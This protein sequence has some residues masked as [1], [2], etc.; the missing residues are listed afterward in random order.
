MI[1]KK[2]NPNNVGNP[3]WL[4]LMVGAL[5]IYMGYQ[6]FTLNKTP[7][8]IDNPPAQ[9][10]DLSTKEETAPE[11]APNLLGIKFVGDITGTGNVATCGQKAKMRLQGIL[12]SGASAELPAASQQVVVGMQDKARAWL[13]AITGMRVGGVREIILPAHAI[14]SAQDIA[15]Y[16]IVTNTQLNLRLF[17]DEL[18]P[19]VGNHD[20]MPLAHDVK[21]GSGAIASC[22]QTALVKFVIWGEDGKRLYSS[23]TDAPEGVE[24]KLG[25]SQLFYGLDWG[26]L[27]MRENGART[28]VLPPA[29]FAGAEI[30]DNKN[31]KKIRQLIPA[32]KT[33]AVDINLVSLPTINASAPAK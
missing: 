2:K 4:K 24:L 26:I 32:E 29:Y 15:H 7:E 8:K 6:Q 22:G 14:L 31:M 1:F 18:T 13:P 25:A 27:G 28:L 33:L 3:T 20:F 10:S 23:N 11:I 21:T 16:K 30:S 5:L 12:P 17:L 9:T 19:S